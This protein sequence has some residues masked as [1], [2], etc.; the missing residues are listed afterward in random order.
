VL[1]LV[2]SRVDSKDV[3]IRVFRPAG[4]PQYAPTEAPDR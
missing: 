4:R 2:G 3:T 1:D